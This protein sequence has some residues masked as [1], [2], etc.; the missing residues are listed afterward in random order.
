MTD[1]NE[2]N[3]IM[4]KSGKGAYRD[5][6]VDK[7]IKLNKKGYTWGSIAT[8]LNISRTTLYTR[9][10]NYNKGNKV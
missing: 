7:V 1:I 4:N 6:D 2:N 5:F 8:E 3:L 10:R 9:V